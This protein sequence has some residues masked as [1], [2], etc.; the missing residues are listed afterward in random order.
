MGEGGEGQLSA[1]RPAGQQLLLSACQPPAPRNRTTRI[2]HQ[3]YSLL[4]S[5]S[6]GD[7]VVLVVKLMFPRPPYLAAGYLIKDRKC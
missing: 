5:E 2:Y 7:V 3:K 4:P 1:E 6:R